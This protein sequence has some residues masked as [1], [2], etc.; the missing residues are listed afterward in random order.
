[1][2]ADSGVRN[3]GKTAGTRKIPSPLR[4]AATHIISHKHM[5]PRQS[6]VRRLS[7]AGVKQREFAET[8]TGTKPAGTMAGST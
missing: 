2:D 1:V 5:E 7:S 8:V 6:R 3:T 4:D